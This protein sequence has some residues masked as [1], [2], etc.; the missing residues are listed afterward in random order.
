MDR[1]AVYPRR[2]VEAALRRGAAAI[3]L[4]HNHPNGDA[5]PSRRDRTLT[6]AIVLA[7]ETVQLRVVDHLI[8]SAE[9]VFSFRRERL[10]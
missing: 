9:Q 5:A 2:V 1:A 3:V 4:A 6:R 8:V 10:L 7:A